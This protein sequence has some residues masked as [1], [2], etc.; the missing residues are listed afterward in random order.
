[1]P[2]AE[3]LTLVIH[4]HLPLRPVQVIERKD[5]VVV[6]HTSKRS[7]RKQ[8]S[9]RRRPSNQ[10]RSKI[11][12]SPS[13]SSFG[14]FKDF[15]PSDLRFPT[16]PSKNFKTSNRGKEGPPSKNRP[17]YNFPQ[18]PKRTQRPQKTKVEQSFSQ[19]YGPPTNQQ[20]YG[21]PAVSHIDTS[22]YVQPITLQQQQSSF[23][24]FSI[25]ALEPASSN[26]FF[27]SNDGNKFSNQIGSFPLGG[28]SSFNVPKTSYGEPVRSASTDINSYQ[29]NSN[30]ASLLNQANKSNNNNNNNNRGSNNGFPKLP[31]KYEDSDFSTP[32]RHNPLK[33]NSFTSDYTNIDLDEEKEV[34]FNN[35]RDRQKNRF[36][37]F[38]NYD[39]D[40]RNHKNPLIGLDDDNVDDEYDNLEYLFSSTRKPKSTTTTEISTT[41]RYRKGA[42]GKRNKPK[43]S[44]DH[45]LDTDDLRDAFTE[46]TN[47]DFHE[48]ALNS[49]D[50]LN[51]DSQRNH[52]KSSSP[53]QLHEIHLTL[54]AA[55][56]NPALRQAIGDD[57]QIVSIQK[58][59]E[60]DPSM[61]D[62]FER[63][64]DA[65]RFREFKV[66][67][68]INFS[69]AA[70][71][72]WNGEINSFPKNHKF[73]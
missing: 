21:P 66:G 71:V 36:N 68:E 39:Y 50:F 28:G 19:S 45:N 10:F 29:H 4:K 14:G 51:F 22:H 42:F 65:Q 12:S 70:P 61:V 55:R 44:Q 38:N 15:T 6:I 32:N 25:N 24:S 72:M 35:N 1:M 7:K 41:K 5:D 73:T 26:T 11:K 48:V 23:P 43:L 64:H 49:E 31:S 62:L 63:R 59:L 30:V 2:K 47:N 8:N 34:S 58:S 17:S 37:K 56:K 9:R 69:Q 67:S 52:R 13:G 20:S 40:F 3:A 60:K 18:K 54:K 16:F 33:S 46:S 57:F 53:S 27:N